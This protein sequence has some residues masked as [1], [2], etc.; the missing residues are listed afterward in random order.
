M[1]IELA[2]QICNFPGKTIDRKMTCTLNINHNI[3]IEKDFPDVLMLNDNTRYFSW[4][5]VKQPTPA[6]DKEF[7]EYFYKNHIE[8]TMNTSCRIATENCE[9][10]LISTNVVDEAALPPFLF[11]IDPTNLY[12][13]GDRH[14]NVT[15]LYMPFKIDISNSTSYTLQAKVFST[16]RAGIHFATYCFKTIEDKQYLVCIDNLK[17]KM[18]IITSNMQTAKQ[19]LTQKENPVYACYKKN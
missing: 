17:E 2:T 8:R 1:S 6:H 16:A 10:R 14:Q 5:M 15:N 4:N 19:I 12:H 9:G 11:V 13:R 18:Y 7:N 3:C